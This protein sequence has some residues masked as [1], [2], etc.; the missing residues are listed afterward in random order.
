MKTLKEIK[1]EVNSW[2]VDSSECCLDRLVQIYD[3]ELIILEK[4]ATNGKDKEAINLCNSLKDA[5]A[6]EYEITKGE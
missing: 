5:L 6:K 4:V 2:L 1:A 3:K